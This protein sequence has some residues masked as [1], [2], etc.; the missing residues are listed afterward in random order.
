MRILGVETS[1]DETSAAIIE[2]NSVLSSIISSQDIHAQFGGVVPELASRAHVRLIIPVVEKALN[3]A[4][5]KADTLDG[6][7]VTYGPGLVGALLVGVQ[8]VKGLAAALNKPF[9]GVNHIEGHIYGNL[10]SQKDYRF[11]IIFLIVSGGHTQIVLME[12]HLKYKI[13]GKTRDDA[14]GEAFDKGAK[15]LGLPYPGGPEIDK[16]AQLGDP[17]YYNF[18]RA[19]L[20]D[21]PLD[22]SY[23]GLKTALLTFLKDKNKN[24]I[25]LNLNNI[26]AAYQAAAIDVLVQKTITAVEK[27]KS[28]RIA[29]AG[30]VAANSLLRRRLKT[31]CDKK[32][33]EFYLPEFKYCTD[34]AAMIA[35]AGYEYLSREIHSDQSLN[36]YP[37]LKLESV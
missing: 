29:I 36:A 32:G 12:D 14:V 27:Y 19:W 17:E 22:F 6:L 13:L 10:L 8:F 9:I 24:E 28:E 7:A 34:N 33:Y 35:R 31:E 30:G 1:C 25:Q 2:N 15:M 5:L 4:N 37:S 23:S 20:K 21:N 26:C 3:T 16:L 11:P 18:P